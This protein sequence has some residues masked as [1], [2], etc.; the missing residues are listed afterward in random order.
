MSRKY[1][2]WAILAATSG[3]KQAKILTAPTKASKIDD[4]GVQKQEILG[5]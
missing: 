4:I 1:S 3:Q 5:V 2:R